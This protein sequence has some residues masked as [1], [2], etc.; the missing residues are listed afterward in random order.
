[1]LAFMLAFGFMIS[2][3]EEEVPVI[4]DPDFAPEDGFYGIYNCTY[5]TNAGTEITETIEFSEK[6]FKISDNEKKGDDKDFLDFE[7]QYYD[8]ATTPPA[9]KT[10]Y[11]KAFIFRGVITDAKPKGTAAPLYG[12]QTGPNLTE[13]DINNKTV[14]KMFIYYD[15]TDG[16]KFIRTAFVKADAPTPNV[17]LTATTATTPTPRVY[18]QEAE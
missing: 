1:M 14:V 3:A 10:T 16:F 17:I 4:E 6:S 2:C 8:E 5:T 13:A 9:Y 18:I 7:I 15:D 11:P 12:P